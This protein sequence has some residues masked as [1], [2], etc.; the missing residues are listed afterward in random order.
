MYIGDTLSK[1][2]NIDYREKLSNN[3][4]YELE[5]EEFGSRSKNGCVGA[6][7]R[8]RKLTLKH[9]I[10]MIIHFKSSIQRELDSFFKAVSQSD[11]KIREVTKGAFTQAR[12]KLNPWAF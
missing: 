12:A 10:V 5:N 8:D 1:N 7:V 6:F 4:S 11:F 9:L 3:I 2:Q